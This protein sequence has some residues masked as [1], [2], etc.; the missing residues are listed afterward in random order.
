M[1]VTKLKSTWSA[2][3]LVFA[4]TADMGSG[5]HYMKIDIDATAIAG[6]QRALDVAF[7]G[8][9]NSSSD[10]MV[11]GQFTCTATGSLAL[12]ACAVAGKVVQAEKAVGGYLCGAEFEVA[13]S[14]TFDTSEWCVLGLNADC[15]QTGSQSD[16]A[17]YIWLR[18]YGTLTLNNLLNFKDATIATND[19]TKLLSTLNADQAA[20]HTIK[21]RA[22][23]ANIW[24]LCTATH[25]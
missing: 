15:D 6:Q 12:W 14:G 7:T 4:N 18:E 8:A 3:A 24:I 13:M 17:A 5:L 23:G 20:S 21:C 25:G 10:E 19:E 22:N 1:P 9:C 2:G 11:A 16:H